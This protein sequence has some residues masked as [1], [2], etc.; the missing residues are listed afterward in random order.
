MGFRTRLFAMLLLFAIVPAALLTIL[1]GV[2]VGGAL[3]LVTG[4]A[5]WDSVAA[6]GRRAIAAAQE[7]P[8]TP[9]QRSALADHELELR[10]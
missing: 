5:G 9:A 3:P 6:T 7:A 2:T 8:L 4:Q 10:A 1:W